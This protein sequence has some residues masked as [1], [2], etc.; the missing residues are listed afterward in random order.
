MQ[1]ERVYALA[2]E[3]IAH[4]DFSFE[5]SQELVPPYDNPFEQ[6]VEIPPTRK[7][8]PFITKDF[9]LD[10]DDPDRLLLIARKAGQV[11]GYILAGRTWNNYIQIDDF[12]VDSAVRRSGIGRLLMDGIVD[13][14]RYQGLPGLRL[15]TQTNNVA[16]CRFY[17]RYGFR[18]GGF[19]TQLY[20]TLDLARHETAL[21]WYLFLK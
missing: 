13:W 1:I 10:A 8:Y 12:A 15:E 5:V 2:P 11:H 9:V 19:D 17:Y 18:L 14:T 6:A 7:T 16:A 3:C 21:F 4:C 20:T